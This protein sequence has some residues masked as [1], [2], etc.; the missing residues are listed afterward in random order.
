[1]LYLNSMETRLACV[2]R[3]R[4]NYLGVEVNHFRFL[5]TLI[6]VVGTFLGFLMAT[7]LESG[8]VR[9]Y[10]EMT[11]RE[12]IIF[13][14]AII[15]L[16]LFWVMNIYEFLKSDNGKSRVL[17]GFLLFFGM[18]FGAIIYFAFRYVPR[19]MRAS[20]RIAR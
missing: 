2:Q 20:K 19:Y 8:E 4:I 14:W 16:V 11:G 3:I 18:Y 13:V 9:V 17:W 5:I 15:G 12:R 1:M 7:E 10:S 6:A